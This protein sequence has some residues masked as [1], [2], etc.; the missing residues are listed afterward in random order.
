MKETLTTIHLPPSRMNAVFVINESLVRKPLM[1]AGFSRVRDAE[2]TVSCIEAMVWRDDR[3][4]WFRAKEIHG[5]LGVEF[6]EHRVDWSDRVQ[7]FLSSSYSA[8]EEKALEASAADVVKA[9]ESD[10]AQRA[11]LPAPRPVLSLAEAESRAPPPSQ[12]VVPSKDAEKNRG[13]F[14]W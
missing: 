6:D 4:G 13:M 10:R 2:T 12:P 9:I 1:L 8:R 5:F 11:P 14:Q 3:K 7:E